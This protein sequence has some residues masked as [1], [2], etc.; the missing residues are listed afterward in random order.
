MNSTLIACPECDL[1]QRTTPLAAD[2]VA[3]CHR[4]ASLLYRPRDDNLDRPLAFT[5]A[6]AVLFVMANL[7]PIVGLELQGQSTVTTLFG[8]VRALYE[9]DM[10]LLSVLIFFTTI[11]VPGIELTAMAYLLV[12]LRMG[13]VPARL[14][15]ALRALQAVRPWGMVEVFIL[16]LLV[17]LAKLAGMATIVPGIAFWSFGGLLMMVAAAVATFDARAIWARQGL[18]Q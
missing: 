17:S 12:P 14:P 2:A 13:R 3:R 15:I 16:G 8:M 6:A 11:L 1:L 18:A 10:M 9:Q 4:C 5:L 7:F